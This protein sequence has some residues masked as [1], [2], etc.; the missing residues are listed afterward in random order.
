MYI[1]NSSGARRAPC[2]TPLV[3]L[4]GC[5]KVLLT[6]TTWYLSKRYDLKL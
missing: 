5:D 6:L 3:T 1:R 2:G 4:I